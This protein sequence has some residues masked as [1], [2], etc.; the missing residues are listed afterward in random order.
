MIIGTGVDIIDLNRINRLV[1]RHQFIHRILTSLEYHKFTT[2]SANRRTEFLAGRFAAKEAF[3]KAL[4]TGI[5]LELSW[6]DIEVHNND[7][8]KPEVTCER[9]NDCRVHLSITHSNEYAVAF[10]VIEDK[11]S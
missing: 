10:I 3:A 11:E 1:E 4:G 7:Q 2:L 6:R 5:G 8:G 9:Y